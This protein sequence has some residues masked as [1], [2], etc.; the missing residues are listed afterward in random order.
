MR[1]GVPLPT[2]MG[3]LVGGAGHDVSSCWWCEAMQAATRA[4]AVRSVRALQYLQW[5][6]DRVH[7]ELLFL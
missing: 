3:F 7:I 5:S 6:V 4:N 2:S 1:Y